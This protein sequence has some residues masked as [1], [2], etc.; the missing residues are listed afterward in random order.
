MWKTLRHYCNPNDGRYEDLS[1]GPFWLNVFRDFTAGLIVAMIAIPLA[2]GLAIAS[3]LKPEMGIIGGAVAALVGAMFGGSKYQVYGPTAAFIPIIAALMGKYGADDPAV[4][5]GFLVLASM[6]SGVMLLGLGLARLGRIVALVPHSIVVGFTIGIAVTIALS[7]VGEML[8]L[9]HKMGYHFMDKVHGIYEQATLI[10]W[11]AVALALCTFLIVKILIRVS[12]FIPGPVIALGVGVGMASLV[13]NH[14]GLVLIRDR[15]GE[16]PTNLFK[17]TGPSLPQVTGTVVL[18]LLYF[19]LAILFV[20]GVESLLCSRMADRLAGNKGTPFD[21]DK[22]LWGQGWVQIIVPL[23]NGFPHTGALART[24]ANIKL[25]AVSPLAGVFKCVLKLVMAFYLASF[26]GMVPMACIGG[27]LLYVATGM[28]KPSEVRQVLRH[29][30]FHIALMAWTAIMVIATDFLVG[31][32]SAIFLYGVFYRFLDREITPATTG[33]PEAG[34]GAAGLPVPLFQRAVI[35][36]HQSNQD[37]ALL[38]YAGMLA[39]RQVIGEL[40]FVHVLSDTVVTK[41]PAQQA[42]VMADMRAQTRRMIPNLPETTVQSHH[43]CQG[44]LLDRLLETCVKEQADLI[45]VGHRQDHVLRR[46]LARRMAKLAPCAVLLVPE[47]TSPNVRKILAPIDFSPAA[48][49]SLAVA[50]KIASLASL[51]EVTAL[52]VYFDESRTTFEGAGQSLRDDEMERFNAFA[53]PIEHHGVRMIPVF[54]EGPQPASLIGAVA[55][56]L[57]ADLVVMESRGRTASAAIL[58]GSVAQETLAN[59]RCPVLV[60]KRSGTQIGLLRAFLLKL[61]KN[62]PGQMFD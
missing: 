24:A 27:L 10:N 58:L 22:E 5:H 20:S 44:P 3:G 32:L 41:P 56:E 33:T 28:V 52:H 14:H 43:V 26:L 60:V 9:P 47:G 21:P 37:S 57:S 19:A 35:A 16:I 59:S 6:I 40:C 42:T 36:L 18:D 55:Q 11:Y 1:K 51:G 53:A 34:P 13:W 15:Y 45:M 62:E 61:L 8:G 29:N 4:G 50:A 30:H 12:V 2:M 31:V 46:S 38:A 25:G 49:T 17:F 48:A 54:R 7:Q 23:L 39:R